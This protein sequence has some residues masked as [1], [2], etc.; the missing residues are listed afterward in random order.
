MYIL[1]SYLA[2]SFYLAA[3]VIVNK[4]MK[5]QKDENETSIKL[6]MKAQERDYKQLNIDFN[7]I[8]DILD[9]SACH[10]HKTVNSKKPKKRPPRRHKM[11]AEEPV[12]LFELQAEVGISVVQSSDEEEEENE[13][14]AAPGCKKERRFQCNV[15]ERKFIRSTHLQRHMRIHT[16]AKPYSCEI[17]RKRFSRSDHVQIHERSH[18]KHKIH[19][20]CVCGRLYFDLQ[21]FIAHCKLHAE[22][23]YIKVSGIT[24]KE[25]EAHIKKQLQ[26]VQN[27][28]P[29][30]VCA[31]QIALS[32]CIKIEEVDT[33]TGGGCDGNSVCSPHHQVFSVSSTE[34]T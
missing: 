5:Q 10:S 2:T 16:G 18:Y 29:I 17:C 20:C 4:M 9:F 15:C 13:Q 32:G 21:L 6:D 8:E 26:I 23:E 30:S 1:V 19:S 11:V 28:I 31:E 34:V 22:C 14:E 7:N 24:A 27:S 12:E 3:E 33:H 25:S